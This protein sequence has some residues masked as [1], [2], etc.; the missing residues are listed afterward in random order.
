MQR[1][2][3]RLW[4]SGWLICQLCVVVSFAQP[5]N[6][7]E[8]IDQLAQDDAWQ[9]HID[10]A[11]GEEVE[12]EE[13]REYLD[14]ALEIAEK[15]GPEDPRLSQTLKA[16]GDLECAFDDPGLDEPHYRWVFEIRKGENFQPEFDWSHQYL[17]EGFYERA[18][19]IREDHLDPN[20]LDLARSHEDLAEV[21]YRDGREN[22]AAEHFEQTRDILQEVLGEGHDDVAHIWTRIGWNQFYLEE[23]EEAEKSFQHAIALRL[24]ASAEPENVADYREEL[25]RF[26]LKHGQLEKAAETFEQVLDSWAGIWGESDS[27]FLEK[28]RE[29]GDVHG[30]LDQRQEKEALR[31]R[32]LRIQER[33]HGPDSI[34][35]AEALF[36]LGDFWNSGSTPGIAEHFYRR[37]ADIREAVE[38]ESLEFANAL[39]RV[40]AMLDRQE[41]YQEAIEPA[42]RAYTIRS[43]QLES[44]D[45]RIVES[46]HQLAGLHR[47]TADSDQAAAYYNQIIAIQEA[48]DLTS[49]ELARTWLS[50]GETHTQAEKSALAVE[51]CERAVAILETHEDA[52]F[53][54]AGALS[55]VAKA[56]EEQGRVADAAAAKNRAEKIRSEELRNTLST[57][58]TKF[59]EKTFG[60][61]SG[62]VVVPLILLFVGIIVGVAAGMTALGAWLVRSLLRQ[63]EPPPGAP[64]EPETPEPTETSPPA[65]IIL[66]GESVPRTAHAG[67]KGAVGA[68]WAVPTPVDWTPPAPESMPAAE[69]SP[70]GAPPII[71]PPEAAAI[72]PPSVPTGPI[73]TRRF[74]FHGQGGSLFGIHIV[75]MLLALLTLGIYYFWGK[76]K[77]L[78]YVY[79][80]A[81]FDGDRFAFHGTGKELFL[82]WL[83]VIP[84]ILLLYFFPQ[85]LG[86]LW[87]SE[88]A[89]VIGAVVLVVGIMVIIPIAQIGAYR[90][91]LSRTS[92]RGIRFSFRGRTKKY[93]LIYLKGLVLTL[94]SL[95]LY[96]PVMMVELLRYQYDNTYFGNTKLRFHAR[97]IEIFPAFILSWVLSFVTLGLLGFWYQ[98]ELA[99]YFW[100]HTTFA[101]SRMR[102]T[103][104]GGGLLW[105]TVSNGLLAVFTLG[106]AY[107]WVQVRTAHYWLNNVYLENELD[108]EVVEQDAQQVSAAAEGM[109]DFLDLPMGF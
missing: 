30:L 87:E 6:R 4:L 101:T 44:T 35:A 21:Y 91:R 57:A 26:Y 34:E 76:I 28:L 54:L 79:G 55:Q 88:L 74:G 71:L 59:V 84:F 50:L 56:Y 27:R 99:R 14:Q 43:A 20:D 23:F 63:H 92:W 11:E 75:N 94:L 105:L 68:V 19:E 108:M 64:V 109:A 24:A 67:E 83:R 95:G 51:A 37:S 25:G 96:S 5:D 7:R 85:I 3:C 22:E 58:W 12:Y 72:P 31:Q 42:Q 29:I 61:T 17:A 103:A 77:A 33:T 73:V 1:H 82:G 90:Y 9:T 15:F 16:L 36:A 78:K 80:Q 65:P 41:R 86:L 40:S 97:A 32:V 18:L 62:W 98:A 81:E 52:G 102:C 48:E 53:E 49:R 70:A 107:P 66:P 104:T 39:A 89:Q 46:L 13:A 69:A 60:S 106:L 100:S 45:S 47:N 10:S 38:G 93:F 2:L 8:R